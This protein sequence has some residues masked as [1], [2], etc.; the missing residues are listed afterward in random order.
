VTDRFDDGGSVTAWLAI[1]RRGLPLLA[2]GFLVD[3]A[4]VFVFLIVLQT[5]L[6]ESLDA[7]PSIAGFALAA[8]GMAKLASQIWGGA[9]SDAH[10]ARSALR[11]GAMLQLGANVAIVPCVHVAAWLVVPAAI[12]YGLGSSLSWPP[13]YSLATASFPDEERAR[14]SSAFTLASG[15]AVVLALASGTLLDRFVSF[16]A[17]MVVPVAAA[18][19][20]MALA[21][22]LGGHLQAVRVDD[23]QRPSL[24]ATV[25]VIGSIPRLAF[26]LLVFAESSGIGALAAAY[27]A[28]GRDVLHVSLVREALLL[29]PA[30]I[31]GAACVPLGGVAA[32]RYGRPAIL[33][34]GFGISAICLSLLGGL[35]AQPFVV[36]VAAF[37]ATAFALALPSVS[38]SMMALAGPEASRGAVIGWFMTTDGLGQTVGPALAAATL[39]DRSAATVM[40]LPAVFFAIVAGAAALLPRG[41][42]LIQGA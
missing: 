27:R 41:A 11:V 36:L 24:R 19:T 42:P 21:V 39:A 31:L 20:A 7:S 9:V 6:P 14:L 10:G 2:I 16:D 25:R 34:G 18:L 8:F 1:A 29:G 22:R 13:I 4:F 17:A 12:M 23:R 15:L 35:H 5:Y 26:S 38:A 28:Y 3:F 33:I 40:L 30:G 37:A 32:D